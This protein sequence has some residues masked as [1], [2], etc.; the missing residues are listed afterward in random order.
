MRPRAESA[1]AHT[2]GRGALLLRL[3]EPGCT[4]KL[5]TPE[6]DAALLLPG[7][8]GDRSRLPAPGCW[9]CW[10]APGRCGDAG[11]TVWLSAIVEP[12]APGC[13]TELSNPCATR[14]WTVR[15][16][17]AV[18]TRATDQNG[19]R[20]PRHRPSRRLRLLLLLSLLSRRLLLLLV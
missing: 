4:R 5:P 1:T 16:T 6:A 9:L 10:P 13:I 11:T 7:C 8:C 19:L 12:A 17:T 20:G 14:E 15:N 2:G 18:H 3:A